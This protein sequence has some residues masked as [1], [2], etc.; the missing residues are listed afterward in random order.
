MNELIDSVL[1]LGKPAGSVLFN[2]AAFESGA[3]SVIERISDGQSGIYAWFR[4]YAFSD[5]NEKFYSE[6]ISAIESPK[7]QPRSGDIVPY[8]GLTIESR[9][10]ISTGKATALRQAVENKS[11][12]DAMRLALQWS[13]LFQ[14]PLYIGKS[15]NLK[16][17]IEQHLRNGSVLRS[18]LESVSIDIDKSYL[19]IVPVDELYELKEFDANAAEDDGELLQYEELFEEV[20]SRL[21]NPSF[22]VRLG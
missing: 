6:L 12:R 15:T 10:K 20:F 11:F 13:I 19:L 18:R 5:S 4:S 17:R 8:Y 3:N 14:A 21:F 2:L 9:S 22:T 1:E 7:F 16:N